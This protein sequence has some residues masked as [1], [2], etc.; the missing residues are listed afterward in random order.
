LELVTTSNAAAAEVLRLSN[1]GTGANTA[2]QIKFLAAGQNYGTITGGYG[3]VAPQ[4]TFDLPSAGNYVW[5]QAA[6]DKMVLDPNGNLVL[7]S[8]DNYVL[9]GAT[10]QNIAIFAN[11]SAANGTARL[12]L[13]GTTAPTNAKNA[14]LR[15][16]NIIFSDEGA[17]ETMR[18][19]SAG[20]VGVG[21]TAPTTGSMSNTAILNAGVFATLR[22]GVASTSGVA[23]TLGTAALGG[24]ETYI[25]SVSLY[26]GAPTAYSA[27]AIV[28]ADGG[29]LR[30]TA[31]QTATL[32][33]IS[34]SGTNIQATQSSGATQTIGFSIIRID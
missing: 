6:V 28:S 14:I 31:L 21:T 30:T 5:R 22:G 19:T 2:A 25:V 34:V 11:P 16:D 26:S 4:T 9:T 32:M 18:I 33:T 23:V 29:V 10:S 13:Y 8:A 1:P 15:G 17:T 27:V 12:E 3:T 24:N 7:T 20:N